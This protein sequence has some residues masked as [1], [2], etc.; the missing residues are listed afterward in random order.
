M[1]RRPPGTGSTWS[2]DDIEE[3]S[4]TWV[5]TVSL[6]CTEARRTGRRR[7]GRRTTTLVP[8]P[9]ELHTPGEKENWNREFW[10]LRIEE[11]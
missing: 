2:G 8:I 1:R 4:M 7:A 6:L 11:K 9:S 5:V 3:G 10:D